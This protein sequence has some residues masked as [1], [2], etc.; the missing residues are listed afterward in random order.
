MTS[1]AARTHNVRDPHAALANMEHGTTDAGAR[2][3]PAVDE[4]ASS[5]ACGGGEFTLLPCPFCG[6]AAQLINR[7]KSYYT[8]RYSVECAACHVVTRGCVME[9]E[10]VT[11]WNR[12]V[13]L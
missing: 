7:G 3:T 11:R 5:Q 1:P 4:T 12:R 6:G 2:N 10:A 9:K 13:K 8:H